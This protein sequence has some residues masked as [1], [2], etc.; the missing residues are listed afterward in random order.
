MKKRCPVWVIIILIGLLVLFGVPIL[1]NELYKTGKGYLTMWE[2]KDMLSYYGM[3]IA[4]GIGAAGVYFTVYISN[5][6]YRVD[7]RNRILPFIAINVINHKLPDPFLEGFDS[8]GYVEQE[9]SSVIMDSSSGVEQNRVFFVID[10]KDAIRVAKSLSNEEM[11][12]IENTEVIWKRGNDGLMYIR[13]SDIL[14]MP[15]IIEN[16]GNGAAINFYIGF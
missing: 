8:E 12:K 11:Q 13:P 7:A 16:I 9:A 3:I 5:K 6:N 14:S 4:A 15:F 1:I 2:A 10:K